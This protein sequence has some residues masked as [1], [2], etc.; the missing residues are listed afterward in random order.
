M[1]MYYGMYTD[2]GN[3]MIHHIVTHSINVNSSWKTVY[4]EL[5]DLARRF[6]E[7][8]GEATDT[9]VRECVYG[10]IGAHLRDE[11]FYI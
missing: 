1:Y 10:A 11:E 7:E 5:K 4:A 9:D 8:F 3:E 2:Q 6:P